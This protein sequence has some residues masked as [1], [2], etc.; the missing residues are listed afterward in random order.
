MKKEW[1]MPTARVEYFST[2]EYLSTCWGVACDYEK[3]NKYEES[4]HHP[5]ETHSKDHCGTFTNQVLKDLNGDGTFDTMIE[6]GTEGLGTLECKLY[7]GSNYKIPMKFS[8]IKETTKRLYWTTQTAD[9]KRVWHHQGTIEQQDPNH[10]N[11]S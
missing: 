2:N 1:I 6:V 4:L 9:G 10:P 7:R 11:R 3:A 5:N 8:D